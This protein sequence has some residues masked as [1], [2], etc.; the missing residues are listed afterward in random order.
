MNGISAHRIGTSDNALDPFP[1]FKDIETRQPSEARRGSHQNRAPQNPDLWPPQPTK[2]QR[3]ETF[4]VHKSQS[5][6][7]CY[8]D[9]I[10][11][12]HV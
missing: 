10:W 9:L 6:V 1:A 4:I 11:P 7:F 8:S 5:T 2:L 12:T 3:K